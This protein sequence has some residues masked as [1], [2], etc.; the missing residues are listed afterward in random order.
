[1]LVLKSVKL[2]VFPSHKVVGVPLNSA[3]GAEPHGEIVTLV[4]L[5]PPLPQLLVGV[6]VTFPLVVP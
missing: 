4:L 2:T 1:M 5:K 3:T 6:T